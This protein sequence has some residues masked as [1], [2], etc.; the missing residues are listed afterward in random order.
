MMKLGCIAVLVAAVLTLTYGN[1]SD[2]KHGSTDVET[3]YCLME[4]MADGK[5]GDEGTTLRLR[6]CRDEFF[7]IGSWT[8]ATN[9]ECKQDV[10]NNR[11]CS[12]CINCNN[13]ATLLT[14][15]LPV[16]KPFHPINDT[17][18]RC[19]NITN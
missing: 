16:P 15:A 10:P 4:M 17:Q 5:C 7:A 14:A 9:C 12:C 2:E 6:K 11:T 13:E 18:G 1:G 19:K 8:M 3:T